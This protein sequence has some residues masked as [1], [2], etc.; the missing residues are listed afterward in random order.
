MLLAVDIGNSNI[1]IGAYLKDEIIFQSRLATATNRTSSQY[2]LDIKGIVE[3]ENIQ[4]SGFRGAIIS[5][6]VPELTTVIKDAVF[7]LTSVDAMVLGPGV[8]SGLHIKIDNPAQLGADLVAGA[9]GAIDKYPLPCLVIDLGT[10][11]K[12]S[13]ID[14]NG[15]YLGCSISAGV[16]ISLNALSGAASLL[17]TINI[18][19]NDCPPYGSN[20]VASMQAG[21]ILG[22]AAMLDGMCARIEDALNDAVA[23]VVAT[24]GFAENIIKYCN[25]KIFFEPNLVLNGLRVIY[26]KNVK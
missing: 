19:M 6:V 23:S 20:T 16:G 14:K 12:I 2:A 3:L 21:T 13:V 26:N 5:S 7:K 4:V 9:V 18:S 22:T 17:P 24:G 8:K 10:A 11:T 1:T 15:A 25:T